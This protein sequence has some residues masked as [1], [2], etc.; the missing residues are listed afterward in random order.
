MAEH[1]AIVLVE[2]EPQELSS[3]DTLAGQVSVSSESETA[4]VQVAVVTALPETPDPNTLYLV[5]E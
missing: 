3:E 4:T 2:G 5:T 1:K